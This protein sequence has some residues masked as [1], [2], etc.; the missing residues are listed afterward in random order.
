MGASKQRTMNYV[1]LQGGTGKFF[2]TS[3]EAKEG[4]EPHIK[5]DGNT[6]FRK[7]LD[8]VMGILQSVTLRDGEY[9]KQICIHLKGLQEYSLQIQFT[10]AYGVDKFAED[11]ITQLGSLEKGKEYRFK[12]YVIEK[13]DDNP[14]ERRGI[15]I[16][17]VDNGD[18]VK[19][20]RT[21]SY[22]K[23]GESDPA[24]IPGMEK[25][26]KLGKDVW[27]TDKKDEFLYAHLVKEVS[28]LSDSGSPVQN[29]EPVGNF[30]D[31]LPF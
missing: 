4:Y 17:K 16:R 29:A 7:Y 20:E 28:R 9:G 10:G 27:N 15:S 8:E 31:G 6:V 5:K 23:R 22:N 14:Y 1:N 11:L 26:V 21:L 19:I 13:S 2:T 12:G 3:K 18:F 30:E 25:T 24:K